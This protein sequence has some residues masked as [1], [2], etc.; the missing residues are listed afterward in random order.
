M[1]KNPGKND[2]IPHVITEEQKVLDG[3]VEQIRTDRALYEASLEWN[4]NPNTGEGLRAARD[5]VDLARPYFGHF[6]ASTTPTSAKKLDLRIGKDGAQTEPQIVS[7]DAD[8]ANA[9]HLR[10]GEPGLTG[11]FRIFSRREVDIEQAVV[12]RI[13]NSYGF[14]T[15]EGA[16]Q[17]VQGAGLTKQEEMPSPTA[18]RLTRALERKREQGFEDIVETI[19]PDQFIEIARSANGP[20]LLDGVAGSGK[21]TVALHRIAYITSAQRTTDVRVDIN[22]VVALGPSQQFINWSSKIKDSLSIGPLRYD[23]VPGFMWSWFNAVFPARRIRF[24]QRLEHEPVRTPTRAT[25]ERV[26]SAIRITCAMPESLRSASTTVT[27]RVDV[28]YKRENVEKRMNTSDWK[29]FWRSGPQL[30]AVVDEESRPGASTAY[31]NLNR[32]KELFEPTLT[33]SEM[34]RDIVS[35]LTANVDRTIE[36]LG[37]VSP[38]DITSSILLLLVSAEDQEAADWIRQNLNQAMA[39]IK[40]GS[41]SQRS[42]EYES[43]SGIILQNVSEVARRLEISSKDIARIA[44]QANIDANHPLSSRSAFIG[45]LQRIGS[46]LGKR[47]DVNDTSIAGRDLREGWEAQVRTQIDDY[48]DAHWPLVSPDRLL[49]WLIG[50]ETEDSD[51]P[52]RDSL[53]VLCAAVIRN[54]AP[55]DALRN[56]LSHIVVDEVQ[57]LSEAEVIFLSNVAR[58]QS[59]TLV[60]DLRQALDGLADSDW[61]RYRSIL[62]DD[63]SIATFDRSYRSTAAITEFCNEILRRRGISRLAEPYL[64]RLGEPVTTSATGDLAEHDRGVVAWLETA[65]AKGGTACIIVPESDSKTMHNHYENLI[66]R[67]IR[68]TR[69]QDPTDG[70]P[71]EIVAAFP[72]EVK[73]LEYNHVAVVLAD[74][75]SYPLTPSAGAALYVA[76]TRAT[77]SLQCFY[78]GVG[79]PYVVNDGFSGATTKG[80]AGKAPAQVKE[81]KQLAKYKEEQERARIAAKHRD[82]ESSADVAALVELLNEEAKPSKK[83]VTKKRV[84]AKVKPKPTAPSASSGWSIF[85]SNDSKQEKGKKKKAGW[86]IF[87]SNDD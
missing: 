25:V 56:P 72:H 37:R 64:D 78:F 31:I 71:P 40:S 33:R 61:S 75:T 74:Q 35:Q 83:K 32:A 77:T 26:E 39:L 81:E 63:L 9:Y 3:L 22:R 8:I 28:P 69:E 59:L 42:K 30:I 50:R 34:E 58:D 67:V 6:I 85:G 70:T 86:S 45:E 44:L 49:P 20:M 7:W 2:S 23:T 62:S 60:G 65:I 55:N 73:G 53:G 76:C 27:F 36:M 16:L 13:S 15:A 48:V 46:G 52:D 41:W 11:R 12:K 10:Q 47:I 17:E 54:I 68:E 38:S 21:T 84:A 19:Q 51:Q 5:R 79:S 4:I 24:D 82:V 1:A 80:Q 14:T 29:K 66:L 87:G 57:E 43:I 18:S